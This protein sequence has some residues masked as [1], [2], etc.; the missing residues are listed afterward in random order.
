MR[1]SFITIGIPTTPPNFPKP[2]SS[3][4][5]RGGG[6]AS[7]DGE[8]SGERA[9]DGPRHGRHHHE[10]HPELLA[11]GPARLRRRH[12]LR[13]LLIPHRRRGGRR[14]SGPSQRAPG[15]HPPRH[16]LTSS[17]QGRRAH[18]LALV[19]LAPAVALRAARPHRRPPRLGSWSRR[20]RDPSS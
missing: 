19:A 18:R 9:P 16:R 20:D 1:H 7:L 4:C 11:P 13:R 10:G 17:R 14:R 8:A 15:Q 6:C 2:G 5:N 3:R 12:P